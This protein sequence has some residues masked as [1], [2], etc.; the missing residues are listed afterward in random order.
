MSDILSIGSGG[1]QVYQRA[2]STTS[3]NIANTATEGYSRQETTIVDNVPRLVGPHWLGTGSIVDS[4]SRNY[5]AFIEQSL[6]T[7]ISDSEAQVPLIDYIDRVVDILGSQTTG[8][9]AALDNFFASARALSSDAASTEL[10][11]GFL[12]GADGLAQRLRTL[13][14]Q[15]DT[16]DTETSEY[17]NTQLD[18]VNTLSKQLALV[19]AELNRRG[20]VS[21]QAPRLLDQRDT[22]L[23]DLAAVTKIR[24]REAASGAVDVSI[25]TTDNRGKIVDGS[26]ARQVDAVIDRQTL[27]VKLVLDRVGTPEVVSGVNSGSLGG[28]L[29]FRDQI[30]SPS[31]SKLDFLAQTIG[32]QFNAVHKLGMDFQGELGGD[33]FTIDPVFSL[34]ADAS[35]ADLAV[36]WEV[37][38]AA[39]TKFHSIDLTYDP[40]SAQWTATDQIDGRKATGL[41]EI[42]INGMLIRIEGRSDKPEKLI[43]EASNRPSL[44]I[45]RLVQDPKLVAAA[46]PFRVIEN[47]LNPSGA[48]AMVQWQ[49]DQGDTLTLP[50]IS[51][52]LES[53]RWQTNEKIIDHSSTRPLSVI[54]KLSAGE[55]DITLGIA[56]EIGSPMELEVF[57]RDGRHLVGGVL[58]E[59]QRD[60]IITSNNGFIPGATYSGLYRN[61]KGDGSY[62]DMSIVRGHRSKPIAYDVFDAT[63]LKIGSEI[64][65]ASILS[66][67]FTSQTVPASG[68]LI[69]A[70]ALAINGYNLNAFTPPGAAGSA[71]K[72]RDMA[73]WL[74]SEVTRLNLDSTIQVSST[75][76][77]RVSPETL[78]LTKDLKLNGV[79]IISSSARPAT[80]QALVDLINAKKSTSNVAASLSATG[81]VIL[82]NTVG[83]EGK[84]IKIEPAA[85][86]L[87]V[88]G[89]K[90][91]AVNEVRAAADSL[92]LSKDLTLNGVSIISAGARPA[93][94]D[95]LVAL[96]NQNSAST[97]V[98]A[99][100]GEKGEVILTNT[101]GNEGEDIVIGPADSLTGKAG[102]ALGISAATY[103]GR[104]KFDAGNDVSEVRLDIGPVGDPS[105]LSRLGL[106]TRVY[107]DGVVPEDLI[108]VARG[109][110]P[111]RFSATVGKGTLTTIESL[112][113]RKL[114]L[115][116]TSD[117]T[118]QLRD[119][120]SDTLLAERPYDASKGIH[121]RGIQVSL[122]RPPKDGDVYVIDGNQGGVGDNTQILRM[123]ALE[124]SRELIPGGL[125]IAES[126]H[127][128]INVVG[129]L[130]NQS[131]IAQEALD[132]VKQQA[133]EARDKVSGVSLDEEAAD[134]IRFQQA[135]QASAR[136]IQTA[137]QL[138]EAI[139]QVR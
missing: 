135:Y 55:R 1:V 43:L 110:A 126:W 67:R 66:E 116:F 5:D 77:I 47:P 32:S 96:I 6:R 131:K 26:R 50:S 95:E 127:G 64:Q 93:T 94:T 92:Q 12:S 3:N 121:Y 11:A 22:L 82:S 124:G 114:E 44:G 53:N 65:R 2:L 107:I 132:I 13:G 99:Y 125:T 78:Q 35:V 75:N 37:T 40:G 133:V 108:V 98:S 89:V 117:T 15:L 87:G 128:Q 52:M 129:N 7:S 72:V 48:D 91:A 16:M 49:P 73:A 97:R 109:D 113:S 34:N 42:S 24:V 69:A 4:I 17:V 30:L 81:E 62:L 9:T 68:P 31:V 14:G 51:G 10:R 39:E 54:G 119:V 80:A 56:S 33:L 18:K 122:S 41:N 79:D 106:S 118:Y 23:R 70:A 104:I 74:S 134:L 103:K 71:V 100:M 120:D 19:N 38:N 101:A 138:F 90:V 115:K 63:G 58:S 102:N 86:A 137:N 59:V 136:I 61:V 83:N 112:R 36:R 21:K 27:G 84:A 123:A 130:G 25:G 29:N 85:N 46:A 105:V 57:T 76:E 139:L 28:I 20:Q 60:A 88:S 111:A 8:L 45:R